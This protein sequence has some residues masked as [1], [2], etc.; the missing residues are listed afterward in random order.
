[1]HYD[2]CGKCKEPGKLICCET[3]SSA[4][5][6]ECLGYEKVF[7]FALKF[8]FKISFLGENSNVIIAK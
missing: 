2:F 5:H 4:Y 3:C 6:F 7:F 8:N 1:M